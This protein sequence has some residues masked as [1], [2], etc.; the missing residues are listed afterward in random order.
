MTSRFSLGGQM[1][2]VED[3]ELTADAILG[4]VNEARIENEAKQ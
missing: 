3:P 2:A 4:L 1:R